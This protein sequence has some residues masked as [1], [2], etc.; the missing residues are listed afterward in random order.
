MGLVFVATSR[1]LVRVDHRHRKAEAKLDLLRGQGNVGRWEW[2]I[3][4]VWLGWWDI[5]IR[6]YRLYTNHIDAITWANSSICLWKIQS[7]VA[8][9]PFWDKRRVA[10]C[11]RATCKNIYST[12]YGSLMLVTPKR[13]VLRSTGITNA[14]SIQ[15]LAKR[16]QM[17]SWFRESMLTLRSLDQMKRPHDVHPHLRIACV[18][19]YLERERTK[20][21][22]IRSN[23][24][25]RGHASDHEKTKAGDASCYETLAMTMKI[26]QRK[27][28]WEVVGGCKSQ[29]RV[30]GKLVAVEFRSK[31]KANQDQGT[32]REKSLNIGAQSAVMYHEAQFTTSCRTRIHQLR[33]A[34]KYRLL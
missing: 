15:Q 6:R 27:R 32:F 28:W 20:S 18:I 19:R 22:P 7:H 2:R 4:V 16:L 30:R 29:G 21:A 3:G 33:Q 11:C 26:R 10:Q 23:E 14:N 13:K 8:V 24:A 5:G 9:L 17:K 34:F 1:R 12:V 31:N 25:N